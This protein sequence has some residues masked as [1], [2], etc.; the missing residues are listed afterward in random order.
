MSYRNRNRGFDY[1]FNALERELNGF[2]S[3]FLDAVIHDVEQGIVPYIE[4]N[5]KGNR[6]YK[7]IHETPGISKENV[8]VEYYDKKL[9]VTVKYSDDDVLKRKGEEVYIYRVDNA[10]GDKI[11]TSLKDG[12]LSI[13]CPFE[14]TKDKVI[15]V[16][17]N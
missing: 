15:T 10:D 16:K 4:K 7:I 2:P 3:Y 14:E 1:Y 13:V 5:E 6:E 9:K 11:S 8:N 12:I 17:I